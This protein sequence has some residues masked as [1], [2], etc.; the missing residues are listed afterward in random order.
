MTPRRIYILAAGL[1]VMALAAFLAV[2]L[3]SLT[4]DTIGCRRAR[5]ARTTL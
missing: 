2:G 3:A 5:W 4:F 1:S